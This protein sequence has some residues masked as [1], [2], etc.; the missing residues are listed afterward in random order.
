[1]PVTG[2]IADAKIRCLLRQ[3]GQGVGQ[4]QL[5]G[6]RVGLVGGAGSEFG[7]ALAAALAQ[8]GHGICATDPDDRA[9]REISRAVGGHEVATLVGRPDD[10]DLQDDAI[11]RA[12][13]AFG[14]IDVLVNVLDPATVWT[15]LEAGTAAGPLGWAQKVDLAAEDGATLITVFSPVATTGRWPPRIAARLSR[16]A[17]ALQ[18]SVGSAS[19]AISLLPP[20]AGFV[21][22]LPPRATPVMP[23]RAPATVPEV[24]SYLLTRRGQTLA[25]RTLK[26]ERPGAPWTVVDAPLT[27]PV[28]RDPGARRLSLG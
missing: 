2:D 9:L 18:E 14:R 5:A 4:M 21:T 8:T 28:F 13:D 17:T 27:G 26:N 6:Q 24:V 20:P 22:R 12:L 16:F 3:C 15:L 23:L 1:V 25:G 11:E 10:P 19:R 7:R